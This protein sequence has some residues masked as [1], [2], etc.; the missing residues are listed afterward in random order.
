MIIIPSGGSATFTLEASNRLTVTSRGGTTVTGPSGLLGTV[1]GTSTFGGYAVDTEITIAAFGEDCTYG[2]TEP[3]NALIA[4]DASGNTVL[5]GSDGRAVTPNLFD[6]RAYGAQCDGVALY[7]VSTTAST[8]C[9]ISSATAAFTAAD[10][11]KSCA[12][13]ANTS[14]AVVTGKYGTITGVTSSGIAT[15]S[16]DLSPGVLTS[17]LFVYGTDDAAAVN[18]AATE[19][20]TFGGTV[21]IPQSITTIASPV[22]IPDG[23]NLMGIGNTVTVDSPWKFRYK[24]SSLVLVGYVAT[25]GAVNIGDYASAGQYGCTAE[26]LNIDCMNLAG[27]A[28]NTEL[29]G[30]NRAIHLRAVTAIRGTAYTAN[31]GASGVTE[32]CTFIQ[33]QYG[34]VVAVKGDSRF[35]NNYVY[36]AGANKH[37]IRVSGMSDVYIGGNHIWKEATLST[38]YGA[39]VFVE[40][41]TG[42]K[43]GQVLIEGNQFDTSFGPHVQI[44]ITG[45]GVIGRGV[46]I[47]GNLGFQND[48]V[49]NATYPFIDIDIAAT[50]ALRGFVVQGNIGCGSW[51]DATKGQYTY[52]IDGAGIAGNIYGSIVGGNV[53][54]NCAALFNL[55]T[56]DHDN[57]NITIA[58]TG[59][60]LTKSVTT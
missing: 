34:H 20:A 36:G 2:V 28:I 25:G 4:T 58:G 44:N 48:F 30:T 26:G 56:P 15:A 45:S 24:G 29:G 8:T 16:L 7:D 52:F 14:G 39:A 22:A 11:G 51:N 53:I 18:E 50:C 12:V 17:A 38:M 27:Q 32:G 6:V 3:E 5:H 10:I 40:F 23:V 57:G 21:F 9:T 47:V 49:P 60:V 37:N 41:W 35:V 55:F 33:Q 46:S 42:Q 59:T 1:D 19:A 43:A 54:D 13:I 31:L